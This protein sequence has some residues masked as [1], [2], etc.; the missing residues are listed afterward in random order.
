[1]WCAVVA[2]FV[3]FELHTSYESV[4]NA[5][6]QTY[7]SKLHYGIII[8]PDTIIVDISKIESGLNQSQQACLFKLK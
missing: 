1:M 4:V 3:V 5:F 7:L 8:H 2:A 6:S